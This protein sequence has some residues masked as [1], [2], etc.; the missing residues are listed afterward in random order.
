ME[1]ELRGVAR[2]LA[3]ATSDG[4]KL[5]PA[6]QC[7]LPGWNGA[8]RQKAPPRS[9]RLSLW[10]P[11]LLGR[12]KNPAAKKASV[13]GW[14]HEVVRKNTMRSRTFVKVAV[15]GTPYLRKVDWRNYGGY[16]ELLTAIRTCSL[17]LHHR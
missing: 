17:L 11:R 8:P 7:C 4:L 9:F 16:Q 5:A 12:E 3:A 14:P 2:S 10:A 6:V 15:D 1:E 13:V